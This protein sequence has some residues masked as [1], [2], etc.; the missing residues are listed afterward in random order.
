MICVAPDKMGC[1]PTMVST[2]LTKYENCT[3]LKPLPAVL[4]AK[5]K[6]MFES[7][8]ALTAN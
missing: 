2:P 7:E 4:T 8:V 6:D 1:E 5:L 3:E